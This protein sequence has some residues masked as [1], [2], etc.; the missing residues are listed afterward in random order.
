MKRN[1]LLMGA[2]ALAAAFNSCSNDDVVAEGSSPEGGLTGKTRA[3]IAINI[4]PD[5]KNVPASKQAIYEDGTEAESK[6]GTTRFY[7]FNR[8]G[9]PYIVDENT[10]KSYVDINLSYSNS[11]PGND[12]I[13]EE[14]N[15]TIVIDAAN[16]KPTSILAVLNPPSSLQAKGNLSINEFKN[17]TDVNCSNTEQFVMTNSTYF[18][19]S[20]V[21]DAITLHPNQVQT[22]QNAALRNPVNIYVERVLAKVRT[23]YSNNNYDSGQHTGQD[24]GSEQV[25]VKVLGW[26]VVNTNESTYLLKNIST[27]WTDNNL[28]IEGWNSSADHRSFWCNSYNQGT[29]SNTSWNETTN[30]VPPVYCYENTYAQND[31]NKTA[32]QFACQL[33]D[34]NGEPIEIAIWKGTRMTADRLKTAITKEI[35]NSG[36]PIWYKDE[37]ESN[38]NQTVWKQLDEKLI[39]FTLSNDISYHVNPI[40]T[41]DA[42]SL[43]FAID[44]QGSKT[45][46]VA[47][48]N[49]I[50]KG[51]KGMIYKNGMTYYFTDI[52]HLGKKGSVAEYGVV[53]NHVY[54]INIT[55]IKGLGTPVFD[56]DVVIM[57][58]QPTEEKAYVAAQI[59]VLSWRVVSQDVELQ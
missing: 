28:G 42:Q 51:Y 33:V 6:V 55:G 36:A 54:D 1:Y 2:L 34:K 35:A 39:D 11:N 53:R 15:P 16:D 48:V 56:P 8:Q 40:L 59:N 29:Q 52:K 27:S 5:S 18:N 19:G 12:N 21:V 49:A 57:P 4:N 17:L 43:T 58:V 3:Y 26:N 23:T 24:M 32:V 31:K 44:G 20:N 25:Y 7:F 10:N 14:S 37:T 46:T 50:L 41:T 38:E 22:S 13:T 47:E 45:Y 9:N 30:T